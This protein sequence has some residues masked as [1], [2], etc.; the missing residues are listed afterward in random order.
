M[1]VMLGAS[2]FYRRGRE[3]NGAWI[4]PGNNG[5]VP[6]LKV[7]L[8]KPVCSVSKRQ[9]CLD[10]RAHSEYGVLTEE[11]DEDS[12]VARYELFRHFR[13]RMCASSKNR[14]EAAQGVTT[15]MKN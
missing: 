15:G 8:M 12:D 1:S 11:C 5:G 4:K 10:S 6:V 14:S 13:D 2:G 3:G 7:Q 9:R